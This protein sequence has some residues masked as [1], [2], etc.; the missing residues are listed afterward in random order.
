MEISYTY[1]DILLTECSLWWL[2]QSVLPPKSFA[3]LTG[4]IFVLLLGDCV[5]IQQELGAVNLIV[6]GTIRTVATWSLW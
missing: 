6:E 5:L 1:S 3:L 2:C 4:I